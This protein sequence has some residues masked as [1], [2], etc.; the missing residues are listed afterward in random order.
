L[1]FGPLHPE[2]VE[3]VAA[4]EQACFSL[5]WSKALFEEE[6]KHPE[7]SVWRVARETEEGPIIGYMGYW[8]A[9]D[10]AHIVNLAVHPGARGRGTGTVLAGHV[11]EVAKRGG[12]KRAT[13]EVRAG[14]QEALRLY[15]RLGFAVIAL[16]EKYYSD[17][18][19]DALIMWKDEL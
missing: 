10:E 6:L 9:V 1:I 2:D 14:N 12:C 19:E 17:N 7:L 16:R 18:Q 8:K 15:A 11:L 5:P 4:L 3:E 13:L